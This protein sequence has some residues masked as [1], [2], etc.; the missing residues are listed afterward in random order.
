MSNE[1]NIESIQNRYAERVADDLKANEEQQEGIR[2]QITTLRA[3]LEQLK[4]DHAWLS[5]M[6]GSLSP[7]AAQE[8]SDEAHGAEAEAAPAIA[9]PVPQPRQE[10]KAASKGGGSRK[11]S[12]AS[13]AAGKPKPSTAGAKKNEG[14]TLPAL[15]LNLL[16]QHHEPRMV[17]EVVTELAQ[18]HPERTVSNQVVRN[19]LESLVARASIE[20]QRRQGSVFYT[21]PKAGAAD[22]TSLEPAAPALAEPADQSVPAKV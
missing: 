2:S 3:R 7:E 10:K 21:A 20:R 14:P 4:N 9:K 19:A 18:A 15:I 1:A 17:S 6:R 8:Q 12:A 11:K 13:K 5:G 16:T 22:G